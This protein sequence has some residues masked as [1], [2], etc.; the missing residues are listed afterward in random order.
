MSK[1]YIVY[2]TFECVVVAES[3]DEAKEKFY[4][5]DAETSIQGCYAAD[6]DE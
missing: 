5:E 2:G 6:G 3:A 1:T 4:I